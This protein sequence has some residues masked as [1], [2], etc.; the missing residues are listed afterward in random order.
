[1]ISFEYWFMF[2][3]AIVIATIA[4]STLVGG[5]TFFSPLFILFLGLEPRV[6]I[7]CALMTQFF[8][9]STGLI[10]YIKQKC[11]D[12]NTGF[13]LLIIT[14]PYAL[15]GAYLTSVLNPYIIRIFLG[16]ILI[17]IGNKLLIQNRISILNKGKEIV[18]IY[19]EKKRKGKCIDFE[20]ENVK[21]MIFST[22]LGSLFLGMTSAGLGELLG[23]NW[24]KKQST[25]LKTIVSTTVFIIAITTFFTSISHFYNLFTTN[26]DGLLLAKDILIFT[27]PGVI[28]GAIIGTFL[29]N[30]I[31]QS[32]LQKVIAV[33]LFITGFL[34]FIP[35]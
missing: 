9:F 18:S 7:A 34:C 20:K 33:V 8:G 17:I 14:I 15:I 11:I 29:I 23:F 35:F 4:M 21:G 25:N 22:G 32:M 28:I 27:V 31:N 26:M 1:M 19:F 30:K 13:F 5:A 24:I 2:P 16:I 3:I 12:Y 10:R 6:A